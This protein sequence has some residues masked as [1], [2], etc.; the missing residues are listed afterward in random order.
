MRL[1]ARV[2]SS[3]VVLAVL[4]PLAVACG[5]GSRPAPSAGA[6]FSFA[7]NTEPS[8]L[9]PHVSIADATALIQRGV[10]DSLVSQDASGGL[11]PWLA[12]SWQV[13]KD[14]KEYTFDLRT[15]VT[16]HDG[17]KL[18]A[19]AVKANFDRIVAR[20]TKSQY[21]NVLLGPYRDSVVVDDHT[22]RVRFTE[23]FQPFL[24][25][26]S[27]AYLGIQSPKGAEGPRCAKV[28]GSGPFVFDSYARQK[29]VTL[30]RNPAY[31]WGPETA[32]HTGPAHLETLTF[33][34]LPENATRIGALTSGQVDGIAAVPTPSVA[35]VEAN[36]G[37]RLLRT[38]SQGAVYGVYLNSSSGVFADARVRDAFR[39]S[40]DVDLLVR[41]T[42]FGVYQRAWSILSPTTPFY[43]KSVENSWTYDPARAAELLDEAGWTARDA[44]G[45]RTKDG[46]RLT[47]RWPTTQAQESADQ[48][49]I[50]AQGIQA[51]VKKAGF[52]LVRD[53]VQNGQLFGLVQDGDYD[54]YDMAWS[55]ADPDILRGFLHSKSLPMAGENIAR[56]D[57][58]DVDSWVV[59]AGRTSDEAARRSFYAKAQRWAVDQAVVVPLYVPAQLVA[60]S[61][62]VEGLTSD[63]AGFP[64]FYDV[65]LTR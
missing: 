11:H 38:P 48:R 50:L 55:R 63:P 61:K 32:G 7:L 58:R 25:A 13:S 10:V 43:D 33:R 53:S 18:D 44:Q 40:I 52:E 15:D 60:V 26:A 47:V 59:G 6:G 8:C 36:Q 56:V 46:A 37:L 65:R 4:V 62:A 22:V 29:S 20:T 3:L 16:F 49:G 19:A 24:Q 30:R 51:A 21:A 23:P 1:V 14:L 57:D 54:L 28:V 41:T 27:T 64:H 31:R 35:A 17:A 39:R 5:A 9:D 45:Y 2:V 34:F 12:R 42:H